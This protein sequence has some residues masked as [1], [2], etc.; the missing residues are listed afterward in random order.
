MAGWLEPAL[1]FALYV[2]LLGLFGWTAFRVL[3][4]RHLEGIAGVRVGTTFMLMATVAPLVSAALMLVS[5]AAMMGQPV[6][7][8]DWPMV[9]AMI[10]G[11]DMGLAFIMRLLL[12]GIG[13]TGVVLKDRI[14][15]SLPMAAFCFAGALVT[16]GWSGHAAAGEGL[17]GLF[18]RLNNGVHLMAA[19]LWIG[20]ISWFLHLTALA[21]RQAGTV[22]APALLSSMQRFGPLGGT[23]VATVSAT[24]IINSELIFGLKN[25]QAVLASNYGSLLALKVFAVGGMLAFG[26]RNAWIG[27]QH[28]HANHPAR[29]SLGAT[30]GSLRRSLACE[31]ALA[32]VAIGLVAIVGTLSPMAM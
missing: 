13:A 18:H 11:T 10:V 6:S 3:W 15:G 16:L 1:R 7:A 4:L 25:S 27:R 28:G 2:L 19:G 9:E 31:A 24:G 32:I 14:P 26:A 20:A 21:H 8:L 17:A 23:L 5:I 29:S 30:L 12:L 22:S